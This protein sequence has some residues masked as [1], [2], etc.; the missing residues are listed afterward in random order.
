VSKLNY[1][2]C[3]R[4]VISGL[5]F[6]F[7]LSPAFAQRQRENYEVTFETKR[8]VNAHGDE[9]NA[10]A[11]S[12]DDQRLFTATEKGDIIVW[13]IAANRLERTLHQPSPVHLIAR[14]ADPREFVAVGW[15]H[16][17]PVNAF[18]RKG[19]AETG[20]FVDLPGL[21][22]N[23]VPVALATETTSGLIAVTLIDGKVL[24]WDARTNQRLA[25]WTVNGVP[26][27]VALLGRDVY[28]ATVDQQFFQSEAAVRESA[29][30]KLSVDNPQQGATDFLRVPGRAWLALDASPDYR[31][32]SAKYQ[33]ATGEEQKTAVIAPESKREIGSFPY[34][35]SLWLDAAKLMLFE[36]LDPSEIV[37]VSLNEPPKTVRKLERMES[38]TRGRARD[39]TG[40]VSNAD[41]SKTW[42]SYR[43]GPGLLEFDLTTN[44]IKTLIGGPSGA[45]T[46]SVVTQDGQSGELLTGGADGYVR[47]WKLDD[48]SL[49]KEYKV[50]KPEHFVSDGHMV[51][52]SHRAV[53]GI[54]R[55]DKETGS[56]D[57]ETPTEVILLNLETGQQRKLFD[58]YS[59]RTRIAVVDNQIV[60]ADE[61]RIKF[62]AID[63][64]QSKR[65]FNIGAAIL[66]TALSSNGRWLAVVDYSK[67][68][69]VFDLRTGRKRMM[70]IKIDDRGPVVMTNDGRYVYLISHE[71]ELTG[72]DLVTAKT[73]TTVLTRIRE[74]HTR[75]DFMTLAHDDRWLVTAGN[76]QDVGIFDRATHRLL[77]YM[78]AGG[79]AHY[80]EKVW[81]KGSRMIL[82]TDIGVMYDGVLK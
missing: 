47:L 17:E 68:L 59:W 64:P 43:K 30:I 36:W 71:G 82:T 51:P 55:I 5:L 40:Q 28:V 77:F 42:A 18:A 2:T 49:I 33:Q 45:Y 21:N 67:K 23:S 70:P 22:S 25:E 29:I 65:E 1:R 13:N 39:L 38:D 26:V 3:A 31:L 34:P 52:G 8:R 35:A 76:H 48:L 81:I 6:A 20:E 58:V 69:T 56:F 61:G 79:A 73:T 57:Q 27:G 14:L 80:V 44:K 78:H 50:A 16:R 75:V 24:V 4:A 74:M 10:L 66:Q 7:S 32:L 37:Q 11:K 15:N 53:V 72:W 62:A 63:G 12:A 41:G 60:Y 46:L 19:N 9:F 54:M